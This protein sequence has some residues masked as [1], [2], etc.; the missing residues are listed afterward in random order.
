M[1]KLTLKELFKAGVHFGHRKRFW[2]PKME[3]FIYGVRDSIH[4]ID[5]EKTLVLFDKAIKYVKKV[6][7]N[8]GKILFVGTK[9]AASKIVKE[10]AARCEMPYVDYRWLGGMLTNYRTVRQSVK[11]LTTLEEQLNSEEAMS[12]FTKKEILKLKREK[13]KLYKGL[14]GIKN[15]ASLPDAL[16]VIDVGCENISVVEANK[17][18]IPVVGVVD[19]NNSPE[20]IGK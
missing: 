3:P 11:R 18:K 1:N 5:L 4:V 2:N 12:K 8:N 16:F 14:N 15:M 10:H 17:L 19:T 7:S 6:A 13:D 20:G 9:R